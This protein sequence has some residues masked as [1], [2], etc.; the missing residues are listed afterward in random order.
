M[1][2]AGQ[3]GADLVGFAG[4]QFYGQQGIFPSHRTGSVDCFYKGSIFRSLRHIWKYLYRIGAFVLVQIA[5]QG[6]FL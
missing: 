1:S 3:M 5:F 2:G 4:D 6:A